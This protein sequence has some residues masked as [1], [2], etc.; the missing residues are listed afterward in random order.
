MKPKEL[1]L[2]LRDF[3]K[4]KS[5]VASIQQTLNRLREQVESVRSAASNG[6][7][8]S[9]K[10]IDVVADAVCRLEKA[11]EHYRDKMTIYTDQLM[12]CEYLISLCS[13][14][15]GRT[16]LREHYINGIKFE[17]IPILINVSPETM[18]R[19]YRRAIKEICDKV[20]SE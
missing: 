16:I 4:I 13:D 3:T 5:E 8:R 11:M 7:P 6:L 12:E 14:Q 1:K 10:I 2:I 9:G 18:W 19:Y 20:D 15:D 17:N